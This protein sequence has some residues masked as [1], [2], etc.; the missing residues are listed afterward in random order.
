MLCLRSAHRGLTVGFLLVQYSVIHVYTVESLYLF[1]LLLY[2][3]L[4]L[5][6]DTSI[7]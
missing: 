5:L 1:Y 3:E 4:Y 6:D 7:S 2:L